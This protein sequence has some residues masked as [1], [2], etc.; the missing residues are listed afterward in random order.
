MA[1]PVSVV[2][3]TDPG[4][5]DALALLLAARW[6]RCRLRAVT[7]TYGNTTL[8]AAN[9]NARLVLRRAGADVLTLPGCDRPL[10]RALVTAE[11]THGKDGL[12][13]HAMAAAQPVHPS[14]SA[15]RDALRA[16]GEPVTL[17]TLGPLTNLA[18]ALRLEPDLV[19]T[20]VARHV[21][22]GGNL[23]AQGNTG[24][25]S[26]FNVWC[27]PEAA[28]EVLRAGL[29]TELVGL[30]VTRQ[31]VIRAAAVHALTLHPDPEAQWLGHLL[32]CYVR[33][34]REQE[35]LAGAVI[36]DPLAI[37]LAVEPSW[38]R[39][40][41]VPIQVDLSDGPLRG[42]TALGSRDAGDPV[43]GVFRQFDRAA[44]HGILLEH[45][46]GRWLTLTDFVA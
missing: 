19:R 23:E 43:I 39:A 42:R 33:F 26:E 5:D 32:G 9:R 2:I 4:I 13:D 34:H 21:A 20:R 10:Q 1:D 22:M 36:N 3:D 44:V 15:L 24:P 30:D 35:G 41:A 29:G 7:V 25:H 27:D 6:P 28:D 38:G 46:F 14:P 8:A 11:D 18:M 17:I 31:L 16:A 37:A 45:L 40:E 12:G